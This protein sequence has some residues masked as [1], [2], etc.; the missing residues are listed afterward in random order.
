MKG[1]NKKEEF[2]KQVLLHEAENSN[3]KQDFNG[4]WISEIKEHIK[5]KWQAIIE[6]RM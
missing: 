2:K 5:R 6:L 4:I 3:A 1:K